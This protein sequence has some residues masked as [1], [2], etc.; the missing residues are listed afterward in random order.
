MNLLAHAILAYA[1]L[2]DTAGQ[3]TCGSIMADYFSGQRLEKYPLAIARGIVHHREI[4]AYTDGHPDFLAARADVS[5]DAPPHSG[6]ILVDLF[7][8]NVLASN[9]EEFG[10][11]LCDM[12]LVGF[13]RTVYQRLER[14][15][16][17][18]SPLFARVAPWIA[19]MD[20]FA[21]Y[22]DV[23]GID[24]ALRGIASRLPHG[25][26]LAD[27]AR[28]LPLHRGSIERHFRSFWPDIRVFAKI[29]A[30]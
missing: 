22:A 11:P 3:E 6:G 27:C 13:S 2:P 12:D 26:L 23:M 19:S 9:W 1:F 24:R 16:A 10:H 20:W 8:D 25:D 28:L 4:D 29:A 5:A 30:G 21:A 14:S 18:H 15:R 17:H 7:W